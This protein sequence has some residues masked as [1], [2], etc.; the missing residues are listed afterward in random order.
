VW[1]LLKKDR[2]LWLGC[3]IALAAVALIAGV[4]P[5]LAVLVAAGA[6]AFAY[7]RGVASARADRRELDVA[8]DRERRLNEL[9]LAVSASTRLSE[10]LPRVVNIVTELVHADAGCLALV[11][12]SGEPT[13]VYQRGLPSGTLSWL[14]RNQGICSEILGRGRPLRVDDYPA[15]PLANPE[16]V[17]EG[18]RGLIGIPLVSGGGA[19]GVLM[20]LVRDEGELSDRDLAGL[21]VA[22]RHAAVAIRNAQLVEALE[23]ELSERQRLEGAG[24]V[25]I[26]EL[27]AKNEELERFAYAVSHDLKSPL[28]TVR[29]FLGFLER[30]VLDGETE[31][32]RD[33]LVRIQEATRRMQ[34]LVD[35]LLELSRIGRRVNPPETLPFDEIAREAAGLVEGRLRARGVSVEIP[36]GLPYVHGDRPRLVGVVQN[37]LDNAAKFMG[38]QPRPRV[39]VG[40]RTGDGTEPVFFVRDNGIGIEAPFREKV[41]SL[42]EK[43]D[44][45]SE[46]TGVGLA[47]VRRIVEVHGGRIWIESA[48]RGQGTTFA[49]TLPFVRPEPGT[50]TGRGRWP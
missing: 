4:S 50:G 41:F 3:A 10:I 23:R 8:V 46:G 18:F 19:L 17:A 45:D 38:D 11:S 40:A 34:R 37:L 31:R 48:G 26:R 21:E 13:K 44:P 1:S 42:F 35:E 20:L 27:S 12:P 24:Q 47:L 30:D 2:L 39:E 14:A 6:A 28:I 33:D 36:A 7:G 22:G 43:L 5:L 32:V 15:H 9:A 49:F 29:G 25:L 16:I